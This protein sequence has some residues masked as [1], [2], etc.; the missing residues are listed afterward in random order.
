MHDDEVALVK[1]L[2]RRDPAALA[3]LY[4]R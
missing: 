2:L 4:D 3:D 1:R